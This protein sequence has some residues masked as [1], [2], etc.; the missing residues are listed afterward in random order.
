MLVTGEPGGRGLSKSLLAQLRLIADTLPILIAHCD[1]DARYLFVNRP[2]AARFSRNPDELVGLPIGS[3]V[4]QAAYASLRPYV[5]RVLSGERVAFEIEVPYE[6][7]GSRIMRCEYVPSEPGPDG[8]PRSFV[9]S[10]L[11]VTDQRRAESALREREAQ[12]RA[13]FELSAVGQA[14]IDVAGRYLLVNDRYCDMTGYSRSELMRLRPQDLTHPGDVA[15]DLA[16]GASLVRGDVPAVTT[17]KRYLRKNGVEIWVRVHATLFKDERGA[18]IGAFSMI[19]DITKERAAI[20]EREALFAR[21]HTARVSAETANRTKDEFLATLSHELRTPLNAILGWTQMLQR[22]VVAPDRVD[23]ALDAL[24]RNARKQ[25]QLVDD[26]L[27]LSR[28]A[29][30]RLKL[31]LEPVTLGAVLDAAI[32]TMQAALDGKRIALT[33]EAPPTPVTIE[34]DPIRLQQVCWNLLSNA[35]KFTPEGGRIA[36]GVRPV[37]DQVAVVVR[38]TGIGI[39]PEF[40]PRLFSRFEQADGSTTRAFQGL[41]LGLAIVRHLVELHGGTVKAESAGKD[42]GAAFTVFL[43]RTRRSGAPAA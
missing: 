4:G 23:A 40:L 13:A 20:E 42:Q 32:D 34:G 3:V 15:R 31:N 7:L 22:K 39:E 5:E 21:E 18:P 2:Y 41:G 19:E 26:L 36:I 6:K 9:A 1:A 27:D 28:I 25:A 24:D 30:G 33:I 37:G 43:P 11:D 35:V 29:S 16:L 38:D 17:T 14:M 8:D 10:I 12:F